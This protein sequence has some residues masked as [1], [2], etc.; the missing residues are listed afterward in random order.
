MNKLKL[1]L[2]LGIIVALLPYLGIP[3]LFKNI[4]FT[5]IGIAVA[6]F[7]YLLYRLHSNVSKDVDPKEQV[8]ENFS[9]HTAEENESE[10]VE[11]VEIEIELDKQ[12]QT[13]NTY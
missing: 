2:I 6:F 4:L 9:E 10:V 7:A 12:N 8:F 1:I 3:Y 13:T 5:L 11:E